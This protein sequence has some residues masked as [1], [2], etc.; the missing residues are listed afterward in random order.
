MLLYQSQRSRDPGK[1]SSVQ[2][3][4]CPCALECSLEEKVRK[5]AGQA[6]DTS[7][8]LAPGG[9][10]LVNHEGVLSLPQACSSL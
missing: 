10:G 6:E 4:Y 5:P 7:R 2:K 8:H 1:G 3:R 9:E